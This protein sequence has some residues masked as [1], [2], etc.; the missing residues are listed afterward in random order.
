MSAGLFGAFITDR[1][2]C[3]QAAAAIEAIDLAVAVV[4]DAIRTGGVVELEHAAQLEDRLTTEL[5]AVKEVVAIVVDEVGAF[6]DGVFGLEG[7]FVA[8]KLTAPVSLD[9]ALEL[10]AVDG[11]VAIVVDL[12]DAGLLVVFVTE[13]GG[14]ELVITDS[15]GGADHAKSNSDDDNRGSH[16]ADQTSRTATCQSRICASPNSLRSSRPPARRERSK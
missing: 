2:K 11:A 9:T 8:R 6:L 10:L 5:F 1:D 15:G 13:H 12:V 14:P 16:T 4:V 7:D 3:A